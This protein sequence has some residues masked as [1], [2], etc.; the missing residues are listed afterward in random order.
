[1]Q[2]GTVILK[3]NLAVS[4]KTKNTLTFDSAITVLD[5]DPKDLKTQVYEETLPDKTLPLKQGSFI[6]GYEALYLEFTFSLQHDAEDST[7][8]A[9]AS[10]THFAIVEPNC[11]K[12]YYTQEELSVAYRKFL[13]CYV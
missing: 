9:Q 10:L 11:S 13:S 2:Q 6:N 8:R 4:Y 12:Y 3:E 1:M 5:M 7:R